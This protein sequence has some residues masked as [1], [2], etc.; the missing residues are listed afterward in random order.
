MFR[1]IIVIL[2]TAVVVSCCEEL[3]LQKNMDVDVEIQFQ[4]NRLI[5][6]QMHYA[7]DQLDCIELLFPDPKKIIRDSPLGHSLAPRSAV[8]LAS[9]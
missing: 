1:L 3:K 9:V 8:S 2:M 5:F 4:M 7:L 6:S